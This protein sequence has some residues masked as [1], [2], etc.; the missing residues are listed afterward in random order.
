MST[1]ASS[2][3][4][5]LVQTRNKSAQWKSDTQT[6]HYQI[7]RWMMFMSTP[8]NAIHVHNTNHSFNHSVRFISFISLSFWKQTL[9]WISN[10]PLMFPVSLL[11]CLQKLQLY[12][13]VR[14]V[15]LSL[16]GHQ[17]IIWFIAVFPAL[18]Q[19]HLSFVCVCEISITVLES[20]VKLQCLV[21]CLSSIE[22]MT[23]VQ[24]EQ[25]W[26]AN[27]WNHFSRVDKQ[28]WAT[29]FFA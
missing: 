16:Q 19:T 4:D 1:R 14:R 15:S 21:D 17:L 29:V 13:N 12:S 9:F 27:I 25:Q 3:S 2:W 24:T 22:L 7:R 23:N 26:W 11:H 5:L 28:E 6:R 18:G 10:V 20:L 8:C